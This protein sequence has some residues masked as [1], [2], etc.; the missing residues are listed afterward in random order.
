MQ[1]A[2]RPT[3]RLAEAAWLLQETVNATRY[4]CR[5]GQLPHSQHGKCLEIPAE[6]LRAKL[7]SPR[8][9]RRLEELVRGDITAPR[10]VRA[11]DPPRP[12]SASGP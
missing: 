5:K 11:S 10:T 8:A 12:L 4:L 1:A 9:L 3:L 2:P 7:R 6:A